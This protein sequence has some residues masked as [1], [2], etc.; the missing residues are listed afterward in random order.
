M[1]F[2]GL[3]LLPGVDAEQ[4]VEAVTSGAGSFEQVGVHEI[5]QKLLGLLR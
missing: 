3:D 1:I 4:V 5:F 2:L